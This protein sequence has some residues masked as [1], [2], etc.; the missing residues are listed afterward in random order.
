MFVVCFSVGDKDSFDNIRTKWIPELRQYRPKTPFILVG[1]QCDLRDNSVSSA[2]NETK[3]SSV[4]SSVSQ[5]FPKECVTRR[6]A[7]VLAR[8]CGAR[9]Y[10][11]CSALEGTGIDAVFQ[12]ALVT[13]VSPKKRRSPKFMNSLKSLFR[14]KKYTDS[15][16]S[17]SET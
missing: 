11:E 15:N 4:T 1:T 10:V 9:A 5:T 8:K 13:A 7:K 3:R 6:Q 16:V 17:V 14:L 12:T 2:T